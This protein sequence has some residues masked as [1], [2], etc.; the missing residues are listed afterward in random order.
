MP[1]GVGVGPNAT[2]AKLSNHIAKKFTDTGVF[3]IVSAFDHAE[4]L[5]EI[6]VSEIWGIGNKIA[7]KLSSLGVTSVADMLYV[8][9][10]LI[11]EHFPITVQRMRISV[12]VTAHFANNVTGG[13][14]R[15]RGV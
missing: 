12:N 11:R 1:S 13:F 3:R 10:T 15:L 6:D 2:L 14:T 9:R 8:D 5:S 7:S 4:L